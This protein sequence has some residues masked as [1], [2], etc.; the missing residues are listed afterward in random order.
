MD[1]CCKIQYDREFD[2]QYA[3]K[4]LIRYRAH[5]LK[6]NSQPLFKLIEAVD[7]AGMSLLDIGGGIGSLSFELLKNGISKS[8][9]IDI[10]EAHI[11]ICRQESCRLGLQDRIQCM[12][13][14]FLDEVGSLPSADLVVLDKVICCYA[15]YELLVKDSIC[16]SKRWYA[17]SIPR[18]IWWVHLGQWLEK[19][20]L[21]IK[22]RHFPTFIHPVF[23]IERI[24]TTSGF[25]K[26]AQSNYKE[27][28]MMLYERKAS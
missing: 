2:E 9:I 6:K 23:E 19:L 17:F 26:I 12:Q 25:H 27:W 28:T 7:L 20:W 8:T 1:E 10:S 22:G 16:K 13:G 24:I 14:D 18:D 21:Q 3:K 4:D 5:G 11:H 15:A